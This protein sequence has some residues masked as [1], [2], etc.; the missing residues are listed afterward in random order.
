[1][2]IRIRRRDNEAMGI[3]WKNNGSGVFFRNID[4]VLYGYKPEDPSLT[5]IHLNIV[6]HLRLLWNL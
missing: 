3:N 4:G 1:M 2:P 5:R 6:R